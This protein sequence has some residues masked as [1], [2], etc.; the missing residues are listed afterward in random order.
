MST[1]HPRNFGPLLT[2]I[3]AIIYIS[4]LLFSSPSLYFLPTPTRT[5]LLPPNLPCLP[6][7]PTFAA[8]ANP[9][10]P[11][12]TGA[13]GLGS[14]APPATTVAPSHH[15]HRCRPTPPS[16]VT[17]ATPPCAPARPW[18]NRRSPP[19]ARRGPRRPAS[20]PRPPPPLPG[21]PA[22]AGPPSRSGGDSSPPATL[23]PAP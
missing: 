2:R 19:P 6:P 4:R 23:N 3:F 16:Q 18:P 15:R 7:A 8:A 14:S 11:H 21:R 12:P 9:S 17:T 13:V 5:H 1:A 22:A 20:P 10:C